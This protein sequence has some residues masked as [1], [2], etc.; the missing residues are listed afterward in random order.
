LSERH[1]EENVKKQSPAI[2]T[3]LA[4][5]HGDL[6]LQKNTGTREEKQDR[7]ENGGKG[8]KTTKMKRNNEIKTTQTKKAGSGEVL[9]FF[10]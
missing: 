2:Q 5:S 6:S 7:N 1:E 8:G 4:Q 9:A 10:S 3:R